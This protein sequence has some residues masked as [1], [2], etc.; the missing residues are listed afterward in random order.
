[1]ESVFFC[2]AW[3][4]IGPY[5]YCKQYKYRGCHILSAVTN[6]RVDSCMHESVLNYA[7]ASFVRCSVFKT[8]SNNLGKSTGSNLSDGMGSVYLYS[9]GNAD[10][11][12]V[13]VCMWVHLCMCCLEGW[14]GG[15]GDVGFLK[16]AAVPANLSPHTL[17]GIRHIQYMSTD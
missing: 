6:Q 15:G 2:R 17:Y 1:M 4:L 11:L 10:D 8:D 3:T 9:A 12:H 7:L 5:V 13:V 16:V 14:G